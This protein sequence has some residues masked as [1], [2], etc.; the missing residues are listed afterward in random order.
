MRFPLSFI[1]LVV[2]FLVWGEG[3]AQSGDRGPMGKS[4]LEAEILSALSGHEADPKACATLIKSVI[5][6][7]SY[8]DPF[9]PKAYYMAANQDY[10]SDDFASAV[11]D[12]DHCLKLPVKYEYL[13]I[14]AA[15]L[16]IQCLSKLKESSAVID[17]SAPLIALPVG[18]KYNSIIDEARRLK[19]QAQTE[20]ATKS[21]SKKDIDLAVSAFRE[22]IVHT[23]GKRDGW[24]VNE[25]HGAVEEEFKFLQR[26]G[27]TS[28]AVGFLKTFL[29]EHPNDIYATSYA[30]DMVLAD[31]KT[32]LEEVKPEDVAWI[33]FAHPCFN[34]AGIRVLYQI[35]FSY[36]R[37]DNPEKALAIFKKILNYQ[38][39]VHTA[40]YMPDIIPL[41]AKHMVECYESMHQRRNA[42]TAAQYVIK[43]FPGTDSARQCALQLEVWGVRP[44]K[45]A[46][47]SNDLLPI[48]LPSL[49]TAGALLVYLVR[50]KK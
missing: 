4:P 43:Q 20:L 25:F 32:S 15:S 19:Y 35:A 42:I 23:D 9:L 47:G 40:G 6:N 18:D 41:S 38:P 28:T 10:D 13:H 36:D 44:T 26:I 46:E 27:H 11:A 48:I 33:E 37:W 3:H 45:K 24:S 12:C 22:I 31:K 34:N 14:Y 16:R 5:A 39:N 29:K 2:T 30:L 1:S 7:A 49:G 17:A 8:S 21:R 50:R